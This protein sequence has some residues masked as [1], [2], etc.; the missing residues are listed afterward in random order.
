[1]C[2]QTVIQ[3][4]VITLMTL[5]N[6][7]HIID[8]DVTLPLAQKPVLFC[9]I[10]LECALEHTEDGPHIVPVTVRMSTGI[11]RKT[12]ELENEIRL[13]VLSDHAAKDQIIE[14][15]RSDNFQNAFDLLFSYMVAQEIKSDDMLLGELR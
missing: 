8:W 12:G 7:T 15:L 13:P 1:M 11:N 6:A 3:R 9:D 4:H 10:T 5:N 2:A 14:E